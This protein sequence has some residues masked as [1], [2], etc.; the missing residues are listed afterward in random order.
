MSFLPSSCQCQS[1]NRNQ[2]SDLM[3][4]SSTSMLKW[5]DNLLISVWCSPCFIV[6]IDETWLEFFSVFLFMCVF[7]PAV[8]P[9]WHDGSWTGRSWCD[10]V[11][12]VHHLRH[13][14]DHAQGVARGVHPRVRQS[15]PGHYQSLPSS[16]AFTWRAQE[17]VRMCTFRMLLIGTVFIFRWHCGYCEK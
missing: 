3:L 11:L 8:F 12:S 1:T 7:L 5:L 6:G 16:A 17:L 13:S 14:H 2:W 15:L 10:S 4:S 9:R